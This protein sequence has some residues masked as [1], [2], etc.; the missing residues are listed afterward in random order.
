MVS[1]VA[2]LTDELQGLS[3]EAATMNEPLD[4]ALNDILAKAYKAG[5]DSS[6]Q[7]GDDQTAEAGRELASAWREVKA[8]MGKLAP[9]NWKGP[10]GVPRGSLKNMSAALWE[11]AYWAGAFQ[12]MNK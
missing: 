2:K 1:K 4:R 3:R 9:P 6:F 8:S 5:Q 10:L 12:G 11:L 7:G